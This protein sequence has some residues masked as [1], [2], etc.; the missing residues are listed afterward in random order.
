MLLKNE[1][2]EQMIIIQ[3]KVGDER[4]ELPTPAV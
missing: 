1:K 3:F 2:R 4:L